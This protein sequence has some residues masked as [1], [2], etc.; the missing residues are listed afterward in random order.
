MTSCI[1]EDQREPNYPFPQWKYDDKFIDPRSKDEEEEGEAEE[2]EEP[3]SSQKMA[4]VFKDFKISSQSKDKPKEETKVQ[5]KPTAKPQQRTQP[6][7]LPHPGTSFV[8]AIIPRI[9][10]PTTGSTLSRVQEVIRTVIQIQS[11]QRQ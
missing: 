2:A 1:P 6:Q 3:T 5:P 7:P 4:D 10:V 9:T 11:F 8:S